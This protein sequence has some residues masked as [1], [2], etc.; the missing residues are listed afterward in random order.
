MTDSTLTCEEFRELSAEL[1][2]ST[3]GGEDRAAALA[4]L[5]HCP[6]CRHELR[7][8]TEVADNLADLA[9]PAEPPIG[10]ESRVI[11]AL[12]ETAAQEGAASAAAGQERAGAGH[13]L[14]SRLGLPRRRFFQTAAAAVVAVIIGVS[15]W[16][17]GSGGHSTPSINHLVSAQLLTDSHPVGRVIIDTGTDPWMS[18]GVTDHG[19]DQLVRCQLLNRDGTLNTVG[20]F[21]V[22][23]G[24]GFW[25]SPVPHGASITGAR[26][27][28]AQG[29]VFAGARFHAT[30]PEASS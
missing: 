29:H 16:A 11:A 6:A 27:V 19:G 8:L 14:R 24:Y 28:D 22:M 9:P 2:L 30:T 12:N 26:L 21:L 5:E 23:N 1:A 15:G 7:S 17:V 4:H 20:T 10:F 18:M 3:L 25:A 13:R